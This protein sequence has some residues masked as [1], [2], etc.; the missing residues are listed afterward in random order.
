MQINGHNY[1]MRYFLKI[2]SLNVVIRLP[3][4]S[5]NFGLKGAGSSPSANHWQMLIISKSPNIE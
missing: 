3:K 1:F 5:V 2:Q 4:L